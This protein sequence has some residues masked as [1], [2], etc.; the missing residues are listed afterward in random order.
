MQKTIEQLEVAIAKHYPLL[1]QLT[2]E[3]LGYRYDTGKWSRKEEIG[4]LIDSAQNNIRR[5][6]EAQYQLATAPVVYN[7][8]EWVKRS[9]YDTYNAQDLIEL[10]RLLNNHILH[11]L[12]AMPEHLYGSICLCDEPRTLEW[13]AEDYCK[14]MEH[15]LQRILRLQPME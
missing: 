7:Q 6:I 8:D 14:H 12:Q 15:H 4:H 2:E 5:F 13:L 10:W 11:I 9:S 1:S 3:E